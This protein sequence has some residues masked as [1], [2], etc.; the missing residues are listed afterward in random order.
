MN[1]VTSHR[2]ARLAALAVV[3]ALAFVA[4][5]CAPKGESSGATATTPGATATASLPPGATDGIDRNGSDYRDFDLPRADAFLCRDACLAEP[6]CQAWTY[7]RPG[8]Q[9]D[10]ARCWLKNGVP[11]QTPDTCCISGVRVGG[12]ST[13]EQ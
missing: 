11:P 8:V 12:G 3:A 13:V 5:A 7:V 2:T 10:T 6:E 1:R 9:G 4:S